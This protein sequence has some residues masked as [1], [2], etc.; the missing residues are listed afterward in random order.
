MTNADF[1]SRPS[2]A[3]RRVAIG[4]LTVVLALALACAA[5]TGGPPDV[6]GNYDV[7]YDGLYR[8][9]LQIGGAR[10]TAN[11]ST[12]GV[13][14]FRTS[15]RG[16]LSL[17]LRGFCDRPEVQCPHETLWTRVSIHQP[18]IRA[19]QPNRHVLNVIESR[20]PDAANPARPG[21]VAGLIG[22]DLEFGLVLGAGYAS[23]ST[24]NAT[25]ALATLSTAT[26]QFTRANEVS[27]SGVTASANA[28]GITGITNGRV[29][30]AFL[31]GCAFGPVGV[32][33]LLTIE[34]TYSAIRSGAFA[35]PPGTIDPV[36]PSTVRP[37][38]D[39]N[40]AGDAS[41]GDASA[42][43]TPSDAEP[44]ADAAPE[45]AGDR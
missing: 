8:L 26:G 16:V 12:T 1:D 41:A 24:G 38:V 5:Q 42:D 19:A 21:V 45:D 22:D 35:P 28:R 6:S 17:D 32:G 18:A 4:S 13:V 43:A 30:T 11:T 23:V 39:P 40:N 34:T 36:D 27:D 2:N 14:E 44:S 29:A 37:G 15:E 33:A 7:R 20:L 25:C 9:T 10:Y 3:R 31:G